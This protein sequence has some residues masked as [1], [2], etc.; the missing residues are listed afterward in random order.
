M[1]TD[2]TQLFKKNCMRWAL[3][4]P[5]TAERLQRV[6]PRRIQQIT[7]DDGSANLRTI[8]PG[9]LIYYVHAQNNPLQEARS[10]CTPS[11]KDKVL[12]VYGA[13]LGYG[14][15]ALQ[16]WLQEDKERTVVFL[17]DD[18]EILFH[19]LH[20]D[21]AKQMLFDKQVRLVFLD[22]EQNAIKKL[23][24]EFALQQYSLLALPF[25]AKTKAERFSHLKQLI[26]FYM[27]PNMSLQKE[28]G[29]Y[30]QNFFSNFYQNML[31]LPGAY[32]GTKL[33]G[34]FANMPAIICG[35]GPSLGKN[36]SFLAT[37]RDNALIFAGGTAMN[38]LNT[39]GFCP[40]F[41]VA[42]DPNQAQ[43]TRLIMNQAFSVPYFYR[44]RVH[45]EAL[46]TIHGN[47]LYITGTPGQPISQWFEQQ[48]G[49]ENGQTLDEGLSV[50]NFSLSIAH[51][52]GCNPILF[53]GAD[54]A[55]TKEESYAQGIQNHPIHVH[56]QHFITKS[57]HED[58]ITRLDIH[59]K[60]IYTLLKWESESQFIS[61]F[62]KQH[63]E[64]TILNATEGG[65]GFQAV[66]N[67]PLQ[68]AAKMHL[69]K[70][71]DFD[72]LVHD[73]INE[74]LLPQQ[75]TYPAVLHAMQ[76]FLKS[77]ETSEK[78]VSTLH[79]QYL[80]LAK[81]PGLLSDKTKRALK[82]LEKEP[83]YT[84][85]LKAFSE[86]YELMCL[87]DYELLKY[88]S[89]KD[90]ET[91]KALLKSRTFAFLQKTI[92][93]NKSIIKKAL[94]T[95]PS[96]LDSSKNSA[97]TKYQSDLALSGAVCRHNQA[98]ALVAIDR[99]KD[100]LL[101]GLQERFY[102]NGQLKSRVPYENGQIHGEVL[103]YYPDGKLKRQVH[104]VNG[105]HHGQDRIWN[106]QGILVIEATFN[107]EMPAGQA[108][109]WHANGTLAL[110]IT[111]ESDPTVFTCKEWDE[112]GR[113]LTN[114]ASNQEVSNQEAHLQA[115]ASHVDKATEV[116]VQ[117]VH[118]VK[119]LKGLSPQE[120][121]QVDIV[122]VQLT[123]LKKMKQEHLAGQK[124]LLWKG[125]AAHKQLEQE[126]Q[127][128][129]TNLTGQLAHIQNT[130]V[131]IINRHTSGL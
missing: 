22:E 94:E 23:A 43:F 66:A 84:Y 114:A 52:L 85:L 120:R 38:A 129:V 73:R 48:L 21:R 7:N 37:L 92:Q 93:I 105:K 45:S 67:I 65:L 3:F 31:R 112:E 33:F 102:D 86:K 77:L 117:L 29:N 115:I 58:V 32:L 13:G 100:R 83:S 125:P 10:W 5:G 130:L 36:L 82:E 98:H 76:L 46:Q 97:D 50:L 17:E 40:H 28:Y 126:M 68:D 116:L 91:K 1:H 34:Q 74:A 122:V 4:A 64:I 70:Q 96:K 113:P 59:N 108:R 44:N 90:V 30:S 27:D 42:I 110:E 80:A 78:H 14:F 121:S 47:H 35:A 26:H 6:L 123:K 62:A 39:I 60:P 8:A 24:L 61:R 69:Q 2:N 103:L 111:Y 15:D 87:H 54:L 51:A 79:Q 75:V 109:K 128:L 9:G 99:Y 71:Y 16:P 41:G 89:P 12:F 56:K 72:T 11:S 101:H 119:N 19:L 107:Q 131:G 55:Y 81:K 88:E 95:C 104:F 53:V 25:Y 127:S 124:E 20:S 106:E 57:E 18:L 118:S 49:I 63:P